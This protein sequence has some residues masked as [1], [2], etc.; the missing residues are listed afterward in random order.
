MGR[1]NVNVNIGGIT[2]KCPSTYKTVILKGSI[3]F[4]SQIE[5]NPNCIFVIKW[6][7]DLKGRTVTIPAGCVLKFEG[8][9]IDNGTIVLSNTYIEG[10]AAFLK[11]VL[12]TGTCANDVFVVDWFDIDHTGNKLCTDAVQ[13]AGNVNTPIIQFG[14]GRYAFKKVSIS[15][16]CTVRGTGR[17]TTV[18]VGQSIV[19][20]YK[21][22]DSLL[23]F[24]NA[25]SVQ[26]EDLQVTCVNERD[27][28]PQLEDHENLPLLSFSNAD[29]VVVDNVFFNNCLRGWTPRVISENVVSIILC[30][31]VTDSV[32]INSEFYACYGGERVFVTCSGSENG[33]KD[34]GQINAT[35][36]NNYIHEANQSTAS[37][38]TPFYALCNKLIVENNR[39]EDFH[40]NVSIFNLHG[41]STYI[42]GNKITGC[43]NTKSVFDCS[44]WINYATNEVI[45][46][47]NI[48]ECESAVMLVV[49]EPRKLVVSSNVHKGLSL[50][51]YNVTS[52]VFIE[53]EVDIQIENNRVDSDYYDKDLFNTWTKTQYLSTICLNTITCLHANITIRNNY[54]KQNKDHSDIPSDGTTVWYTILPVKVY[55]N[56]GSVHIEDNVI[57]DNFMH[58]EGTSY[59]S[60]IYVCPFGG[61]GFENI[62]AGEVVV[63]GNQIEYASYDPQHPHFS[64]VVALYHLDSHSFKVADISNMRVTDNIVQGQA[65]DEILGINV[66]IKNLTCSR[67]YVTG[68]TVYRFTGY[69]HDQNFNP[70][71]IQQGSSFSTLGKWLYSFDT[72]CIPNRSYTE[73]GQPV[74]IADIYSIPYV[75]GESNN[76]TAYFQCVKTPNP[77]AGSSTPILI[78]DVVESLGLVAEIMAN[79][80]II[81]KDDG[82]LGI[83]LDGSAWRR[84]VDRGNTVKDFSK[85]QRGLTIS[86]PIL[87]DTYHIGTEF[88]D[89]TLNRPIYWTGNTSIGDS[90]W[91]DAGGF[92]AVIR[93]GSTANRP[94][95]NPI[96]D[97]GFEYFDTTLGLPIYA[98]E[99]NA[100]TGVVTWKTANGTDP[101]VV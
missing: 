89:R 23:V 29:K 13:S 87:N 25:N 84:C 94:T 91:V 45:C 41:L 15:H 71:Y 14:N 8:G 58:P 51:C 57:E 50:V 16:S 64:K 39:V 47:N 99:I 32:I 34:R 72:C 67:G 5:N 101:D 28:L 73:V 22:G 10:N 52:G 2:E 54:I 24:D 98:T 92:S 81:Q 49:K 46:E 80:E 77:P 69:M 78:S 60:P 38:N 26:V 36:S 18:L 6:D 59:Y 3:P 27:D 82:E 20:G 95:L 63:S 75:D 48:V 61:N 12:L 86:R 66:T 90:G 9:S 31:D 7:F 68:T 55:H 1:P 88:F 42:A 30:M 70:G 100:G 97:I 43:D 11:N 35:F 79:G 96:N 40:I 83:S 76:R 37:A 17:D 93:K 65:F 33:G 4:A 44:E 85:S 62:N 56:Y 53:D 74:N 19:E 21:S